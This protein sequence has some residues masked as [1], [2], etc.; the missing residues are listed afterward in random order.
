[1]ASEE[2]NPKQISANAPGCIELD[3]KIKIY[4]CDDKQIELP[5]GMPRIT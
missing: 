4:L 2:W 5:C 1:M 3:Y